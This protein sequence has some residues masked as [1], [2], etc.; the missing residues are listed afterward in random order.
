M[1]TTAVWAFVVPLQLFGRPL[2]KTSLSYLSHGSMVT[3]QYTLVMQR[4]ATRSST[5]N[6]TEVECH[7]TQ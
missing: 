6:F 1:Y 3:E 4:V 7:Q 5:S 2:Y